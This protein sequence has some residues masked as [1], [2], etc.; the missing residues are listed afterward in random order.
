MA[1]NAAAARG[2]PASTDGA[3][4]RG[5]GRG[6]AASSG[7]RNAETNC[8]PGPTSGASRRRNWLTFPLVASASAAAAASGVCVLPTAVESTSPSWRARRPRSRFSFRLYSADRDRG[9]RPGDDD[10]GEQDRQGRPAPGAYAGDHG[11]TRPGLAAP[12]EERRRHA[13]SARAPVA[14][15]GLP[16][17][18]ARDR[19]GDAAQRSARCAIRHE[20]MSS[21]D[22][23]TPSLD[24]AWRSERTLR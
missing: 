6:R 14:H 1:K 3:P 2:L 22:A 7:H 5:I 21:P 24:R 13:G 9:E 18:I 12:G 11:P 8:L 20:C 15:L 16:E 19:T 17:T 4:S 23:G 10:P